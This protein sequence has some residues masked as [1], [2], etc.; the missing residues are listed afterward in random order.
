MVLP[1]SCRRA[2]PTKETMHTHATHVRPHPE[3]PTEGPLRSGLGELKGSSRAMNR[4]YRHIERVA[5]TDAPVL[6]TGE[7]GTG[8]ELVARTIHTLSARRDRPFVAVNCG[9]IVPG[10]IEAELFGHEKGSFTG[11]IER[12]E[13][14]FEHASGGTLFLDEISEMA[15]EMQVKLLQVLET[16]SL[17]RV[18]GTERIAVDVRIVAATHRDLEEAQRSGAF[19]RDLLYRLAVFPLRVPALREREGDVELLARHFV[20]ELNAREQAHKALSRRSIETLRRNPWPGNVRE[21]RNAVQRAYIMGDR[22]VEVGAHAPVARPRVQRNAEGALSFGV[23]TS[24]ADAQREI[25]LATLEHFGGDKRRT[26]RVLGISL[27]TLYNRLGLYGDTRH[28]RRR[29]PMTGTGGR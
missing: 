22:Q 9:A 18:G 25:L 20:D 19:R 4:L 16:R 10:L 6:I 7:S 26:A 29:M 27:K 12:R 28:V 8:K 14:Y 2:E 24:L 21:L 5:A 17:L 13:G 3:S 23:G 1:A 11:A 15:P